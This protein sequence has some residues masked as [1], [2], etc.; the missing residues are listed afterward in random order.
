MRAGIL[1]AFLAY[2]CWGLYPLYFREL[3]HVLV[4]ETLLQRVVWSLLFV[5]IVLA[6]RRRWAWLKSLWASPR[7]LIRF[8]LAALVLT[9]NWLVFIWAQTHDRV[10]D[11]SLGYFINPLVNV[12]VG[13]VLLHERQRR[14]QW[15]AVGV[16]GA[17]VL[18]LTV[19]AGQLPWVGLALAGFWACYG[20]LRKTARLGALEG[21]ALETA[22]LFP[23]ALLGL[24]LLAGHGESA[25][26]AGSTS[27]R[28]LLIASGPLT[29]IPLL[30][31]AAG[32]RRI[33]FSLLGLLQYVGPTLHVII[34]YW[35]FGV[36]FGADKLIGFS[37]IWSALAL[38]TAEGLWRGRSRSANLPAG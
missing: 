11:A 2:L 20:F 35:L 5:L 31:F 25:F 36:P 24:A 6:L 29:S 15:F 10:I 19:S 16:A 34:G 14:G 3:Q 1:Y 23:F 13:A 32:A 4:T 8:A 17:G 12:L 28:L 7:Q 18:W 33:P 27:T 37:L 9:G 22:L 30:L 38:Y 26:G 21:L